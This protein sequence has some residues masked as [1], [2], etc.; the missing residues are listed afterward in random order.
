MGN[1]QNFSGLGEQIKGAV[2]EALISGDFKTL[3]TLVTDTV[4]SA[5]ADAGRPVSKAWQQQEDWKKRQE[6]ARASAEHWQKVRQEREAQY[7]KM[8]SQQIA[9]QQAHQ[10]EMYRQRQV[11]AEQRRIQ[12]TGLMVPV[13]K[14]GIV[15]AWFA[16]VI[17]IIGAVNL[18]G[19]TIGNLDMLINYGSLF[20]TDT[21]FSMLW[22]MGFSALAVW[23]VGRIS[24]IR[25][26]ERYVRLCG[27]KMYATVEELSHQVGRSMYK[28]RNDIRKILQ[29][30]IVPSAH[31]DRHGTCFMLNDVVY[32]QYLQAED[33]RTRREI[34]MQEQKTP[35]Q[36]V[37]E[38]KAQQKSE[39]EIMVGEGQAYI[40]QLR[41]LNDEIE[42]EEI[43]A[44]LFQLEDLLKEI[45]SRV[46]AEPE[47]MSRMH[48]VM[49]YY[50]PTTVKLLGAY[51]EFD[52]VSTPGPDIISAK[53]E[54]EKTIDTINAAF[55]ELLNTLFQN[56]V[57]DI[58]TDA[59]VLQTM[60]A[61]EGLTKEMAFGK[62][63]G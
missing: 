41:D 40:K 62:I 25:R 53:D 30:G 46:E 8:R 43:S 37:S 18:F 50:L 4:N 23:G 11:L 57:F 36:L 14:K 52:A 35:S 34:E 60:L 15:G 42:G 44:K 24:L 1:S 17:G 32:K 6:N 20:A 26:A 7:A 51:K 48:K 63:E 47:Q 9:Q 19:V 13:R 12:R 33:S 10:Q 61:S 21:I 27:S 49:D 45:F 39:L 5:L 54:I 55:V 22:C 31:I 38:A 2:N 3:N 28:I 58:T 56:K 29:K 59:Q 16:L